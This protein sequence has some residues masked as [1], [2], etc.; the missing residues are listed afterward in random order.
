MAAI[1]HA[2]TPAAFAAKWTAGFAAAV[3]AAGVIIIAAAGWPNTVTADMVKD[4]AVVIDVGVN[5]TDDGLVGDVEFDDDFGEELAEMMAAVGL[6]QNFSAL[7]ALVTDGIQR[8]HMTLHA[9]SV[10]TAAGATP[11]GTQ[12]A[13]QLRVEE[14]RPL[15]GVDM[16]TATRI[17]TLW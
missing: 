6:A 2:P 15:F 13:E 12:A 7:R 9:R 8:G 5:R 17:R 1:N 14:G 16:T 4:G 11:V 3:R 10:A